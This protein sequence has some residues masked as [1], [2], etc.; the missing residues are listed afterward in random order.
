M[1]GRFK[2]PTRGGLWIE[3][4]PICDYNPFS[5]VTLF[6][7]RLFAL[8]LV[9]SFR[10]FCELLYV[11]CVLLPNFTFTL[12]FRYHFTTVVHYIS[13]DYTTLYFIVTGNQYR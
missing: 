2:F 4:F 11:S 10:L 12:T 7:L 1:F 3:R 8:F 6:F 9:L 5:F 13:A